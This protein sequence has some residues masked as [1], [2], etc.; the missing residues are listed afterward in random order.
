MIQRLLLRSRFFGMSCKAPT[1]KIRAL[2][3]TPEN[4]W[5]GDCDTLNYLN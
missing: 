3:D 1:N 2:R 4:R 5:D